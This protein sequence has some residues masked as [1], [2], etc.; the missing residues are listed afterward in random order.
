MT[1][2]KDHFLWDIQVSTGKYLANG[3]I[4]HNSTIQ[5][6]L[7]FNLFKKVKESGRQLIGFD[8]VEIG[9]G[10]TDWDSNVG[11]RLLWRMCNL[12]VKNN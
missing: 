1:F 12:M 11:A 6:I 5:D 2:K 4:A 10:Q 3:I 7:D 8:L 9:V